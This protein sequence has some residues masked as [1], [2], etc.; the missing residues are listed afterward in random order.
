MK[1]INVRLGLTKLND[2]KFLLF[3]RNVAQETTACGFFAGSTTFTAHVDTLATDFEAAIQAAMI[4]G[5]T[6]TAVRNTKRIE[7]ENAVNLLASHVE[8][9]CGGDVNKVLAAGFSVR[10]AASPTARVM[11]APF[12]LLLK[13]TTG[14]KIN[15]RFKGGD[16]RAVTQIECREAG[17]STWGDA[18]FCT[19]RS[20]DYLGLTAG[21]QYEFRVRCIGKGSKTTE[22]P[23]TAWISGMA[24]AI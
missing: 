15:V 13:Q 6:A 1:R 17:T 3:A 21:T 12:D 11:T 22:S 8:D 24:F 16:N 20:F 9:T 18:K 5:S 7:L 19:D 2:S 4:G 23:V 14:G 10:G